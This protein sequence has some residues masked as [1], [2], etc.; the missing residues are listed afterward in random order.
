MYTDVLKIKTIIVVKFFS[1]KNVM[2]LLITNLQIHNLASAT[3][4]GHPSH[5]VAR[6]GFVNRYVKIK[7]MASLQIFVSQPLLLLF[8]KHLDTMLNVT[9]CDP[10]QTDLCFNLIY[11]TQFISMATHHTH[12]TVAW[13]FGTSMNGTNGL[14]VITKI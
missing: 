1:F 14:L 7:Q 8:S 5:S 6:N 13:L 12:L 4:P 10:D 3:L 9:D 11:K 2:Y